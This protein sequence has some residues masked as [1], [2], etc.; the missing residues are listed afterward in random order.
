MMPRKCGRPGCAA[1]GRESTAALT[2][3]PRGTTYTT[4]LGSSAHRLAMRTTCELPTPKLQKGTSFADSTR[5]CLS[6]QAVTVSSAVLCPKLI[7][8][9][10][11][12]RI[13][14]SPTLMPLEEP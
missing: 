10:E 13:Q 9:K 3:R 1:N 7:L 6:K 5:W 8:Y 12:G 4:R 2:S 14:Q 11:H